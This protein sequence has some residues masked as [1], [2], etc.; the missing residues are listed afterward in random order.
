MLRQSEWGSFSAVSPEIDFYQRDVQVTHMESK[1]PEAQP[2]IPNLL[3]QQWCRHTSQRGQRGKSPVCSVLFPRLLP[4]VQALGLAAMLVGHVAG[5]GNTLKEPETAMFSRTDCLLLV[6]YVSLRVTLTCARAGMQQ[7]QS[8][9]RD[10]AHAARPRSF[11]QHHL[12]YFFFLY[13]EIL[14]ENLF[15]TSG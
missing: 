10:Y 8:P 3:P 13:W 1:C 12:P 11:G 7:E 9:K 6:S 15:S 2:S 14:S 4:A 5:L